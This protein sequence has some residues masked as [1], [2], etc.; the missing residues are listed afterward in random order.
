VS[1][2]P[3]TSAAAETAALVALLRTGRRDPRAYV[4]LVEE[5]GSAHTILGAEQGLLAGELQDAAAAELAKWSGGGIAALTL[6]NPEYPANLRAVY[7]HPPLIF[8]AGRLEQ[9]DCRSVAVIGS[10][11]A[12]P[13]GL[14]RTRTISEHLA[15]AGY[16]VVS[17]LAAGIDTAAHETALDLGA[18]TVA[19]IGTGLRR[20]YPPENAQLQRRIAAEGAVI[21]QFWPDAGPS[22]QSF[23][24]RNA[25]M[26]GLALATVI[27]EAT[28]TSG[29]RIQARLALGHGRP[30]LL[31]GSLL[32]QSW[33]RELS[34]R[35]GI[36]VVRS[37]GEL[38][39]RVEGLTSTDTLVP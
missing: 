10:R 29:A 24:L 15:G 25:V 34:T 7:D 37:A 11:K 9:V 6:L 3:D 30:V 33:A 20:A 18:R 13:A 35:P 23:P 31:A 27:V 8:V 5:S 21:S 39:D 26:S 32:E 17:G 19:V 36:H 22:R 2:G 28:Q 12:T 1:S 14:E 16:T 38:I 4:S